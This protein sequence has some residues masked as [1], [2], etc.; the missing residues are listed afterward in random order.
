[1]AKLYPIG[2]QN[3]EK[4]RIDNYLY[5]DKTALIYQLVKT[6]SYYFLSRP[7]R[8]GKSLLISTLEAY[9]QGKKEL[10]Q[11]LAIENLEKDWIEYPVLH[12]DLNARK[13]DNEEA[14]L[15]E[16][17]KYLEKWEQKYDSPYSDRAPEERFY[18]IIQKAFEKTGQRVV[19]LVD[20]YDKP[21]LQAIGNEDL[22]D[23]YRN[24]LKA[25]YGVLKSLDGYIRFALLTGVTKFGK[26]SVFSDLNN[27]NDISWMVD[28]LHYVE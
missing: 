20:E 12:L 5:L 8:F 27:L 4:I 16:L 18:W 28:M 23:A 17:N 2:I 25:F 26:I 9:F 3:F 22:Q 15:Q 1:M 19:I 10:F 13:Y 7:R 6:G 11:G 21:M 14:L 24:T